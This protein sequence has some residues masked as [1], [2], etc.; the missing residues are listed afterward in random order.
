MAWWCTPRPNRNCPT[1]NG[2]TTPWNVQTGRG[3]IWRHNWFCKNR[4]KSEFTEAHYSQA[5]C[6]WETEQANEIPFSQS[7]VPREITKSPKKSPLVKQNAEGNQWW[8]NSTVLQQ[9][10]VK[11]AKDKITDVWW[12]CEVFDWAGNSHKEQP[13]DHTRGAEQPVK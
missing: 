5:K 4:T 8:C 10:R 1:E 12:R 2:L 7:K 9:N 6:R 13:S 3:R 11:K